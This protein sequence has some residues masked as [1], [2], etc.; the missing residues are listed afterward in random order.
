M[1]MR[2]LV[3]GRRTSHILGV[4]GIP[5]Y[6][7]SQGHGMLKKYRSQILEPTKLS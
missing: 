6:A 5:S 1:L 3:P 4:E 7:G 2:F